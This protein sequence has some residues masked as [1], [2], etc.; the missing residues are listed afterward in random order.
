MSLSQTCVCVVFFETPQVL[1]LFLALLLSSFSADNL[2]AVEDDSETNNI[3]IA[4]ARIHSGI[5]WV[6]LKVRHFFQSLCI[7]KKKPKK[8]LVMVKSGDDHPKDNGIYLSNHTT[9]EFTKDLDCIK[10][11]NGVATGLEDTAENYI[12]SNEDVYLTFISNPDMT[13][14][15]PIAAGESDFENLNTEDFSNQSSDIEDDIK[16]VSKNETG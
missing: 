15:V 5:V 13:I 10:E 6:K 2:T 7:R 12:L 11:G 1:N 9:V 8:P 14:S 3:Q 16:E 4:V